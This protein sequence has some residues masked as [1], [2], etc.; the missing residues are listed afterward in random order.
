MTEDLRAQKLRD[1]WLVG[2]NHGDFV[3]DLFILKSPALTTGIAYLLENMC[4]NA[5]VPLSHFVPM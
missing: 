4:S 3:L 2:S 1:F 5:E